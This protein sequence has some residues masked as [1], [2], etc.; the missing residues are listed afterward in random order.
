MPPACGLSNQRQTATATIG[1]VAQGTSSASRMSVRRRSL[2]NACECSS[3]ASAMPRSNRTT[4]ETA[5]SQNAVFHTT[6]QKSAPP[7]ASV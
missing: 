7:S 3:R 4:T 6:R 2:S 5:V 1:G